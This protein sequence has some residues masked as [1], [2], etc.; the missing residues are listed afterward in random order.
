MSE[1]EKLVSRLELAMSVSEAAK[2]A[3]VSRATGYSCVKKGLW[4]HCHISARRIVI[5][6]KLF[7]DY[8]EGK[9]QPPK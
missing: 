5:P 6:I 9:W 2:A 3:K 1:K 4:P 8:L 7:N